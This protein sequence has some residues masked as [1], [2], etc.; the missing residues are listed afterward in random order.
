MTWKTYCARVLELKCQ[1][2][3]LQSRPDQEEKDWA[4]GSKHYFV[5]LERPAPKRQIACYFSQGSAH[6]RG[7]QGPDVLYC[8]LSDASSVQHC[9]GFEDWAQELGFDED[10]RRTEAIYKACEAQGAKTEQ[11]LGDDFDAACEASS[12]Y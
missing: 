6:K 2:L 9:N 5:T 1:F 10:S 3:Q 11:F 4:P 12:D 7:P 8:L